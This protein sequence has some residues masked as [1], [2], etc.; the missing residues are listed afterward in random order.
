M[1]ELDAAALAL[2][3]PDLA[4]LRVVRGDRQV[5]YLLE[6]TTRVRTAP[7]AL[8]AAPDAKR[9]TVGRWELALPVAGMRA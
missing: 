5:P 8:V 6:R 3:R 9:P 1:L 7:L 4:D 2:S